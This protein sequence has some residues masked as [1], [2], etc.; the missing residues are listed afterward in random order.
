MFSSTVSL[1]KIEA[2]CGRYDSPRRE[3]RWMGYERKRGKLSELN[4]FL[5]GG[6]TV[7][8]APSGAPAKGGGGSGGAVHGKG[9]SCGKAG[10]GSGDGRR[11]DRPLEGVRVLDVGSGVGVAHERRTGVEVV[12]DARLTANLKQ[13]ARRHGVTLYMVLCAAWA[14]LLSRLSGQDDVVTVELHGCLLGTRMDG[15]RDSRRNV[16]RPRRPAS[17]GDDLESAV[18]EVAVEGERSGNGLAADHLEAR[19]VGE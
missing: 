10:T 12:L 9:G 6:V 1:R 3:R 14:I 7:D 15:A 13:L 19:P 11:R 5:R 16:R 4:A 17:T 18:A 2:S 8:A